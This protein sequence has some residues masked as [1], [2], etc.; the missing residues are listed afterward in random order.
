M[1]LKKLS[2]ISLPWIFWL[3]ILV[4]AFYWDKSVRSEAPLH[5]GDTQ[6]VESNIKKAKNSIRICTW[7][8][9]NYSIADRYVNNRWNKE[10]PKPLSER[11]DMAKIFVKINADI[12]LVQE[13]GADYI[14]EFASDLE[15]E[16]LFYPHK[17][18]LNAGDK[19]R[20]IAIFSKMPFDKVFE[21]AHLPFEYFGEKHHTLRGL[22]G[23]CVNNDIYIYTAHLKSRKAVKGFEEDKENILY[24]TKEIESF[25]FQFS[26]H[27][28]DTFIFAADFNDEPDSIIFA[29]FKNLNFEF[30]EQYDSEKKSWTYAWKKNTV[31]FQYDFFW[32]SENAKRKIAN[33]ARVFDNTHK[34]SDHRPVYFDLKL[35]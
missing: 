34:A 16:N 14:E 9:H 13:L 31:F 28:D 19:Q 26:Q 18:L 7:N 5:F 32:I 22:L 17:K 21:Y 25:L 29:K 27:R 12:I 3:C 6:T 35:N 1:N 20:C 33:P 10:Y 30:L 24:R 15:N 2:K 11:Q 8:L 4:A 23:V